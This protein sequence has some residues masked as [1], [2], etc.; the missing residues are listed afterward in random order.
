VTDQD[1]TA[2]QVRFLLSLDIDGTLEAG[3]PPGPIPLAIAAGL[4]RQGLLIGSASDR[5][6]AAQRT[7]WQ[8]AGIVPDFLSHKHDLPQNTAR[9]AAARRVHIGDTEPDAY[10]ARLAGFDFIHV[11][12]LPPGLTVEWL[13]RAVT[14]GERG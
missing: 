6:I 11:T 3:D 12:E 4:Q 14:A 1:G 2:P 13:A 8:A 10:Y 9:L 5:T 7:M